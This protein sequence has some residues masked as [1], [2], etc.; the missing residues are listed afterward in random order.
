MSNAGIFTRLDTVLLRVRDFQMSKTW[1]EEKLGF[2]ASYVSEEEKL[3]VFDMGGS[4]SFTIWQLKPGEQLVT[5]GANGTF[6]IFLAE[7]AGSIRERMKS[8][9]IKVEDIQESGSVHSFGFFDP[10]GNRLEVCQVS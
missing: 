4:T 8:M 7:D 9:G 3:A 6:P 10:D 2:V 5:G 1:Y